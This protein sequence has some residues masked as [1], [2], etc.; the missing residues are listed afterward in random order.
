LGAQL[1]DRKPLGDF[2]AELARPFVDDVPFRFEAQQPGCL[3]R[4]MRSGKRYITVLANGG[5]QDATVRL[6]T[7]KRLSQVLWGDSD[8][9]SADRLQ[10]SLQSK[11]TIVAVWE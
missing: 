2:L 5:S 3:L 7:G 1:G 9:F 11:E 10:L 6:R 4:Q 8:R